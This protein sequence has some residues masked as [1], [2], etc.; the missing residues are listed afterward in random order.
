M[1]VP[2]QETGMIRT[3]F[4]TT[5]MAV[6]MVSSVS[7]QAT[8]GWRFRWPQGQTLVY[9]VE[10]ITTASETVGGKTNESKTKLN[11]TKRWQVVAVDAQGVATLHMSL[12]ALRMETT[13]PNNEVLLFD[14]ANQDKSHPQLREQMIKFIGQPLAVLR[15]DSYGQV[16]EVKESKYGPASKYQNELPFT[17]VLPQTAPNPGQSWQRPYQVTLDPPQGAGE[18]Y[19]AVQK[20]VCKAVANGTATLGVSNLVTKPPAALADQAPLL[21]LQPEGEVV[22]DVQAG[23][24]KNVSLKIEKELKNHQGEGSLYKFQSSYVEQIVVN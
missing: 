1:I 11:L 22:F 5:L 13:L 15:V 14:S 23:R 16:L 10:Q 2:F 21:Q 19:D 6:L 9:T 17:L 12:D 8:T 24:L 3:G 4:L 18:K 7:A 20:C